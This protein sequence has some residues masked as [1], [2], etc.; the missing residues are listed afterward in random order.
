MD[1]VDALR[2]SELLAA[3]RRGDPAAFERLVS[4]HRRELYAH[5]YRMLGLVQDAEDALQESLLGAWRGLA[6]F[7]GRSSLRAWLY[8][9]STNAC[10]RL[11]SRRPR[12]MLSPDHGPPRRD[13]DDL[14]E[15]VT[16][17]VWLEPWWD[18]EP[19]G[20]PGGVD[21]AVRYQRRESVELAFVAALQHLPGTQRAVLILRDG[22]GVLR[23][24]GRTHPGHHTGLG[25]QAPCSVPERG[26]TSGCRTSLSKPNWTP[27]ARTASASWWTRS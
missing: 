8:R 4:R 24:R 1:D 27:S 13:T 16:G 21:P 10:L 6:S 2:Q 23:R 9:V 3:A 25:E 5:C 20:E 26:S 19:A 15:P 7:E 22:A 17:P 18:D 11:I 14:G 12:R